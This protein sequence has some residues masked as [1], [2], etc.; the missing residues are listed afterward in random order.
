MNQAN[1]NQTMPIDTFIVGVPGSDSYDA[2]AKA[3]PPY[4]MRAAL[5]DIAYAGSPANVPASCTHTNPFAQTDPDP[6][7]SCH[8]DM[9][10]N[11]S[12]T[13]LAS[14]IAQVRGKVLGCIF[15]VPQPD[16]GTVDPNKVN[17]SYATGG[18]AQSSLFKRATPSTDCS[19]TGCWDY[20]DSSDTKVELFGKACDDVMNATDADVEVTVGCQTIV[21]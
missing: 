9:T 18:G 21:K 12:A 15:D 19:T 1:T 8:F 11:Y 20:T 5:S 6:S 2:T 13:Q 16:G 17:V 7:V 14:A 3:Y 4:H 10:Q